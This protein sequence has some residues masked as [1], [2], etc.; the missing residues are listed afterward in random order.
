V[1]QV[2]GK[3]NYQLTFAVMAASIGAYALLQSLVIP[4]L[5]TFEAQLHT[6]QDAATWILTAYLLSA[7]IFT[8]IL[9]RV[10]DMIGKER[11]FVATLIALAV[12]SVLAALA[13]NIGIM[14]VARVIQGVAG[15]MIPSA[16]GIIRD[17]FPPEKVAGAVGS[18]ASLSAVGAGL[19]IVLAGPI[20]SALGWRYLFWLPMIVTVVAA[21]AAV[22]VIPES[23]VRSPGTI[24]W[25]PAILL[26]GWLVAI[27][28]ALSEA[29]VWGWGS[30]KV[31]GLLIGG[32]LL[33]AAWVAA[34][35]RAATPLVD[36]T[37][38]RLPA[39]WT[40]NLVSLLL[41][42]GMYATFAFLPEFLQTPR[43]LA[44][45]GFSASIIASGLLLLPSS[46]TM[47][48]A[49][50]FAG[51]LA[52]LLGGKTLV[53][54]G[55]LV[56]AASM[57][58][59]AFAH[60]QEWEIAVATG[61]MGIGFGFAYSAMSALVVAAVP[62]SQTGVATGM[63]A[64]IRTIGGCIGSAAM[65]SIVVSH[66]AKSG[67]PLQSGYTSGFAVMA[68]ALLVAAVAGLLIP[69]A[70]ARRVIAEATTPAPGEITASADTVATSE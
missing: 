65:A 15:G 43:A 10:G 22:L 44:G 55:C 30:P 50:Q 41:G 36:M 51:R 16:F 21:V 63:N 28:V 64:N 11:V 4:V 23:P 66:L 48:I 52:R 69:A 49:G 35:L 27:L 9:G 56:S 40:N 67:L 54:W 33:A 31:I 62:A 5:T 17:E 2:R 8:P 60:Q 20:V 68:A 58:I 19:G 61:L 7:S 47:F 24:S 32:V 12:G 37:M 26:S 6:S 29:P 46:V 1:G 25:L 59:L 39:V 70:R 3:G 38:M 45:Y 18:L 14:I 53:F 34:E 13:P 57:A 42:L